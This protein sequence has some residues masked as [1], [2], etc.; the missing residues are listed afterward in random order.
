MTQ[1]DSQDTTPITTPSPSAITTPTPPRT[2][3]ASVP[4]RGRR[5]GLA[6]GLSA[7]LLGGAAAGMAFGIP[8]VSSAADGT[9]GGSD[10]KGLVAPVDDTNTD[11]TPADDTNTDDTPDDDTNTDD[12]AVPAFDET[13]EDGVE[14]RTERV[15]SELD[16]LVTAG[17]ITA[18]QA[19]AVAA[20]LA[21]HGPAAEHRRQGGPGRSGDE[22]R[23]GG[24]GPF[25]GGEVVAEL[26]G[27]ENE[28]VREELRAGSTLGEIAEAN[29]G[30]ADDVID[31]LVANAMERLDQAVA[32][33]RIDETT[34]DQRRDDIEER[35][36]EMVTTPRAER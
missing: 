27:L 35:V 29:G 11:D 21:E 17:T 10:V 28:T 30:S 9:P 32:D 16:E 7:G 22:G 13:T 6:I 12:T 24:R 2:V 4:S 34:A 5:S 14:R 20:H 18:E 15:R 33:G 26:L 25:A 19:D 36:T 1:H 3:R 31:A 23:F 8:G